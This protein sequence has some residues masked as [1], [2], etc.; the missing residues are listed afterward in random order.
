MARGKTTTIEM[1]E[2][3]TQPT[4]GDI[5]YKGGAQGARFRQEAGI[6]FQSTALQD[7]LTV[8]ENLNFFR[9]LYPKFAAR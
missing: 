7:F 4:S 6:Q 5:L 3:I 1:L 2:G 9:S 8:R